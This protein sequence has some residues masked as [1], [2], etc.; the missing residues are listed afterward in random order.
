M[1]DSGAE[2]GA[3][4]ACTFSNC[5]EEDDMNEKLRKMEEGLEKNEDMNVV[6]DTKRRMVLITFWRKDRTPKV[7]M[8]K[9]I[10]LGFTLTRLGKRR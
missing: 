7:R 5:V 3:Q 10:K 9:I 1:G 6:P 8:P 4:R 2:R